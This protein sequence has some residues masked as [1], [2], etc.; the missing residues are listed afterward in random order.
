MRSITGAKTE[1]AELI[2]EIGRTSWIEAHGSSAENEHIQ[3]YVDQKY[4]K[5]VILEQ[6][7]S[8]S[9]KYYIIHW[10]DKPAGYSNLILDAKDSNIH[11]LDVAELDRLY[12][13]SEFYNRKLGWE[14]LNFNIKLAKENS[15]NGLWLYVWKGNERALSFY[16][17]AGFEIV[18]SHDFQISE[19]HYNPNHLM[20]LRF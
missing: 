3:Y 7:K 5:E 19:T 6:I 8:P 11:L 14:L 12:L 4:S 20:L 9:N 13:L 15:Q 10:N 16:Q 17:K 18:G 1:D 2:A